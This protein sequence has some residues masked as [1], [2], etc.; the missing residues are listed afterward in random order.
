MATRSSTLRL[1]DKEDISILWENLA[2]TFGNKFINSFGCNDN[3][4]WFEVL[5]NLTKLELEQGFKTMLNSYT[6]QER[7]KKEVW[8]P[9]A[10]EFNLYCQEPYKHY[11]MPNLLEAYHEA[12]CH[13]NNLTDAW[14][15][16]VVFYSALYAGVGVIK[17][18][19]WVKKIS[20]FKPYYIVLC[21]LYTE[22]L[23]IKLPPIH[24]QKELISIYSKLNEVAEVKQ[25]VI[26]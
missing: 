13:L 19:F 26:K 16:P 21:Q 24:K 18:D 25:E 10:K 20:H 1:I 11:N 14:S 5:K 6:Q 12:Q 22:G 4:I 2:Q 17:E 15:H 3:G 8:P 7:D 9:N 23:S